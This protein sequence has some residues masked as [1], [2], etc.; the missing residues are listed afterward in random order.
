MYKQ[1]AVCA[2][3]A[4]IVKYEAEFRQFKLT[5][6]HEPGLVPVENAQGKLIAYV[7]H[8]KIVRV[9]KHMGRRELSCTHCNGRTCSH[10]GE[11]RSYESKH[12]LLVAA[13]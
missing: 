1:A 2:P 12:P 5:T 9:R 11:V 13:P 10:V 8:D 6:G 3:L 4:L 7:V